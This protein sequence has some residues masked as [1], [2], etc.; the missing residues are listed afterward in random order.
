MVSKNKYTIFKN[1]IILLITQGLWAQ[2]HY[3]FAIYHD[4][5]VGAW[6]IPYRTPPLLSIQELSYSLYSNHS[7]RIY[8]NPATNKLNLLF[9]DF[10]SI[11][12]KTIY[13]QWGQK[14]LEK[15]IATKDLDLTNYPSGMYIIEIQTGNRFLR[16]KF[17]IIK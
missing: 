9:N 4:G 15:D 11:K 12:K 5:N 6:A 3:D 7:F 16:K 1:I 13:N 14:V 2:G 17:L 8:P 10:K